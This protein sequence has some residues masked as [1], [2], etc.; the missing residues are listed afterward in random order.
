MMKSHPN[1]YFLNRKKLIYKKDTSLILY[2]IGSLL[3]FIMW[4][5]FNQHGLWETWESPE[6]LS[7]MNVAQPG[8][9]CQ[10]CS[11][12]TWKACQTLA[13]FLIHFS[14]FHEWDIWSVYWFLWYILV[15]FLSTSH[16]N[17]ISPIPLCA[18]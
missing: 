15:S 6:F 18:L 1:P 4:C 2:L 3:F 17:Y 12:Q 9:V 11:P 7:G 13:I 16:T 10:S 14:F 5:Q 8:Q